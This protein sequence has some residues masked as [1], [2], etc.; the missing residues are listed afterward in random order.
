MTPDERLQWLRD[1]GVLVETP[2]ERRVK[3][4]T[5]IMNEK[6]DDV[7]ET[8]SFVYVPHDT[9]KPLKEL[10][11]ECPIKASGVDFLE[12]HLKPLFTA[13]SSDKEVDLELLRQ[14]A[15]QTL[16]SSDA[17]DPSADTLQ[18]VAAQGS[19]EKFTLVHSTEAN[20]Y[21]SVY[22]Y[23]DEAGM[24]KRL[25]L[26]KR[27]TDFA[28]RA[29][30]NP[31]PQFYGNVFLGRVMARPYPRNV[32]FHLGQDT[33]KDAKWLQQATMENLA[34]QTALNKIT[35]R[36]ETQAAIAGTDGTEKKEDAYSWT[37]TEEELEMVVALANNATSKDVGV[38]FLPQS[39]EIK[40]QKE[41]VLLLQ[42]FEHVD[43]DGC[44]WTLDR[45]GD[46]VK[47]VVTLEKVEQALWPRIRD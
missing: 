32:S 24:L 27:A 16:G 30:Y 31:A 14:H 36:N 23:L 20:H 33:A 11:F 25:P 2:E 8:V 37:Q 39:I 28:A 17:P 6:D 1:R 22:I 41:P 38:K 35:G 40:C 29:G 43:P 44:T 45:N 5:Q 7:K 34:H 21:T 10:T 47:L 13:M 19:V 42:F 9:S 3:E 46:E 18:K 12:N 4:V 26:N 15:S